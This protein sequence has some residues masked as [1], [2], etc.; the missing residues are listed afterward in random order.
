MPFICL[1]LKSR[2]DIANMF[3]TFWRMMRYPPARHSPKTPRKETREEE[4]RVPRVNDI[5]ERSRASRNSPWVCGIALSDSP[6]SKNNKNKKQTKCS[7]SVHYPSAALRRTSLLQCLSSS[8]LRC[9]HKSAVAGHWISN[10]N[11]ALV[12]K[13]KGGKNKGEFFIII[14][15]IIFT[16][17]YFFL[18]FF[19]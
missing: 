13:L 4:K 14:I 17:N 3:V 16:W 9:A 8:C 2:P 1:G 10:M 18:P 19:E 7:L 5:E 15:I 12:S 11:L 6:T